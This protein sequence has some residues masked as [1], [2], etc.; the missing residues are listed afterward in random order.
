MQK[1]EKCHP[2]LFHRSWK[3]SFLA[4]LGLFGLKTAGFFFQKIWLHHT[5]SYTSCKKLQN[6]CDRISINTPDKHTAQF[7]TG[8]EPPF[9]EGSPF[10]GTPSFWSKF[11]K[12]PPLS[13][14]HPNWCMQIV[15]NTLKW[16]CYISYY[17]K[18][19]ENII[20]I[21]LFTFRLNSVF[22]TDTSFG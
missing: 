14:S 8:L 3:T 9:S 16:R 2:S 6:F 15:W 1:S 10:L 20:N 5:S 13:E 7:S 11:K 18:S 21:T 4:F 22:T 12:L 17:T 19:I